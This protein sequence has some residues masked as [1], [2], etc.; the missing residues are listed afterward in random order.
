MPQIGGSLNQVDTRLETLEQSAMKPTSGRANVYLDPDTGQLVV[1]DQ[2]DWS[3]AA[4]LWE[5]YT[6]LGPVITDPANPNYPG[7]LDSSVYGM[8]EAH[9]MGSMC[10]LTGMVR[11]KAGA[12]SLA[13]NTRY[14]Q[15][16]F[17]LPADWRPMSNI[18]LPCLV[19]NADPDPDAGSPAGTFGTAWIEIRPENAPT[20]QPSGWVYF[21]M[22]TLALS[23]STGWIS[24][25]G[26]FPCSR[27]STKASD[28]AS[29]D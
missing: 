18:I 6:Q 17:G 22:G 24:L 9:L 2:L 15:P 3:P 8:A 20:M 16:M 27:I 25:Q 23:A 7:G 29:D 19:G 5:S 21:V 12:P 14:N 10:L 13:A 28:S 11:R 4:N 26:V 1:E